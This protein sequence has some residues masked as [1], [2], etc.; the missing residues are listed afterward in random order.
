MLFPLTS[1]TEA[2]VLQIQLL[3]LSRLC[4]N[5][6]TFVSVQIVGPSPAPGTPLKARI[7]DVSKDT[8]IVDVSLKPT[9]VEAS[10]AAADSAKGEE[11]QE[12]GT[13]DKKGKKSKKRKAEEALDAAHAGDSSLKVSQRFMYQEHPS[14]LLAAA[15]H[16]C[17]YVLVYSLLWIQFRFSNHTN[18]PF[19]KAPK[20]YFNE[21]LLPHRAASLLMPPLIASHPGLDL[22]RTGF[23]GTLGGSC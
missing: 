6:Q 21:M 17:C 9:M 7:L 3:M 16:L 14:K 10:A 20:P 12:E 18:R 22:S 4:L 19:T 23:G 1:F 13:E 11:A 5:I 15:K 8:G 2:Q